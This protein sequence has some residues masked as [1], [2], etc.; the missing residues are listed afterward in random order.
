MGQK[1]NLRAHCTKKKNASFNIFQNIA[2]SR[3]YA[4]GLGGRG[5]G[6]ARAGAR[7]LR[8]AAAWSRPYHPQTFEQHH[9]SSAGRGRKRGRRHSRRRSRERSRE[10]GRERGTDLREPSALHLSFI[11][12]RPLRHPCRRSPPLSRSPGSHPHRHRRHLPLPL[13]PQPHPP[14]SEPCASTAAQLPLRCA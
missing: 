6:G 13:C 5:G 1:K 8:G 4:G 2:D 14:P 9:L 11:I 12:T 7:E 3:P 10:R